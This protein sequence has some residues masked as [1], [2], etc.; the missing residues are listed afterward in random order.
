MFRNLVNDNNSEI[1][2][3][4]KTAMK[5]VIYIYIHI[6]HYTHSILKHNQIDQMMYSIV[7]MH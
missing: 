4:K 3:E 1:F 6:L 7:L 5:T 2:I